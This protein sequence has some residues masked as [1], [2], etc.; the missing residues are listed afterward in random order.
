MYGGQI[1]GYDGVDK[2][3]DELALVIKHEGTIYDLMKVEQAYA[4]PFSSAKD[5]VALAGYV[6]EDIITGKTILC[7]GENCETLKW[8]ISSYWMSAPRMNFHWVA[9]RVP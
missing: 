5:P 7:I 8:K 9:Y 1:V 4:P 6:A 2:R 3:I